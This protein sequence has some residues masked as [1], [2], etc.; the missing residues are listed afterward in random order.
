MLKIDANRYVGEATWQ[1]RIQIYFIFQG[2]KWRRNVLL[3]SIKPS[4]SVTSTSGLSY[5]ARLCVNSS[6]EAT[7]EVVLRKCGNVATLNDGLTLNK[8]SK[9]EIARLILLV[10]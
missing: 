5:K 2:N 9:T 8:S 7:L 1:R 4:V 3:I 6:A 10:Y